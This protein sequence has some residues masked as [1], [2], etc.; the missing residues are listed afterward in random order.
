MSVDVKA[1]NSPK[2]SSHVGENNSQ[3][4]DSFHQSDFYLHGPLQCLFG[5]NGAFLQLPG[6]PMMFIINDLVEMPLELLGAYG[7]I[8]FLPWSFKPLYA[9][10]DCWWSQKSRR[11][12]LLAIML[13]ICGLITIS[14]T[15]IP[16]KGSLGLVM[17]LSF[18]QNVSSAFAE[19]LLGLT[20]LDQVEVQISMQSS[21]VNELERELLVGSRIS[22]EYKSIESISGTLQGQAATCRNAGSLASA[23]GL[24]LILVSRGMSLEMNYQLAALLLLLSGVLALIASLIALFYQVGSLPETV[25]TSRRTASANHVDDIVN[26]S[27]S[28]EILH[29]YG[30]TARAASLSRSEIFAVT[31]FQVLIIWL[32]LKSI[33]TNYLVWLGGIVLLCVVGLLGAVFLKVQTCNLADAVYKSYSAAD[34][35]KRTAFFLVLWS[36]V[37]SVSYQWYSYSYELF[38]KEPLLLQV[39]SWVGTA[40]TMGGSYLFSTQ[41]SPHLSNQR[42]SISRMLALTTLASS[43]VSLLYAIISI[44]NNHSS[45]TG[46]NLLFINFASA[47]P[48]VAI[49]SFVLEIKFLPAVALATSSSL[50]LAKSPQGCSIPEFAR[51][52]HYG[53]LISCINFGDQLGSWLSVPLVHILGIDR[54]NWSKMTELIVICAILEATSVIFL[55]L[56]STSD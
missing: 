47:V 14:M 19:F 10:M 33:F 38:H 9:I 6:L 20:L 25:K 36:A 52:L 43:S 2:S 26:H 50:S 40:A 4:E 13:M 48:I 44:I 54:G 46:R 41:L 42:C 18:S 49:S 21:S 31:L 17:F 22:A 51:G 5:F 55:P 53:T 29:S 35:S 23:T 32:G 27:S 7:A 15:F 12:F 3:E 8:S 11:H 37:P 56:I 16:H 45:E 39:I 28:V 24:L 30:N 1:E 34:S